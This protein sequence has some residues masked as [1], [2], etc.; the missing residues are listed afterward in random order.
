MFEESAGVIPIHE[1]S[2]DILLVRHRAGHWGLPK[3]HIEAGE[4]LEQT[5]RRELAEETGIRD[6]V[7]T[8]EPI[9]KRYL[10]TR[11]GTP[12]DKTVSYFVGT[13]YTKDV[14]IQEDELQDFV[15]LPYKE[16]L[17]RLTYQE[18]KEVLESAYRF[19]KLRE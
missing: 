18:S 14:T 5:A 1:E 6:V 15:W 3:G 11:N 17:E 19:S 12:V 2:G 16:A 9:V 10:I 7:L 8:G 13:V 4:S